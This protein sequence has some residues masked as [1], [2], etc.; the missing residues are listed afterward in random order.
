VRRGRT[1]S[2]ADKDE[3][4]PVAPRSVAEHKHHRKHKRDKASKKSKKA[5]KEKKE[6][7]EKKEKKAK[8]DKKHKHDKK[9]RA[10]VPAPLPGRM[11]TPAVGPRDQRDEAVRNEEVLNGTPDTTITED[12]YFA[13]NSEFR[14]WLQEE[15]KT[16]F[17]DLTSDEAHRLFEK[18]VKKWNDGK[19][20]S[21]RRQRSHGG[22]K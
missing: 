9:A 1:W 14:L 2:N 15:R 4:R 17:D 21:T 19:L 16:Y 5:K 13:R 8:K 7:R 3:T 20:R 12:D 11:P 22:E 18:F 6:K 10:D